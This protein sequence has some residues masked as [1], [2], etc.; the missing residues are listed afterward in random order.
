MSMRRVA[1][2]R[3]RRRKSRDALTSRPEVERLLQAASAP[4]SPRELAREVAAVD[5]FRRARLTT[6]TPRGD[7]M[8]VN[9]TARTGLKAALAA[10]AAVGL[11][12]S[13]VAFAASGHAPWSAS[14]AASGASTHAADPTHPAH[15]SDSADASDD[16]SEDPSDDPS[17]DPS[18]DSDSAGP[19]AHAFGGLCRAYMSGNKAD[20]GQ[21]LQSPPFVALVTAAGGADN[22]AAFCDTVSHGRSK[23][24]DHPVKP[25]HPAK[26][27]EAA[28]PAHPAQPTHPAKPS[29]AGSPTPRA[30]PPLPTGASVSR[31]R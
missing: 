5:A 8:T 1:E 17:N 16:P 10:A 22:V 21:A 18:D 2:A 20:H 13:G 24:P 12:C 26:P 25:T 9:R 30:N 14:P 27:S 28:P 15:P 4:A 7:E 31:A 3:D 19:N 11:L 23:L 29:G 6:S